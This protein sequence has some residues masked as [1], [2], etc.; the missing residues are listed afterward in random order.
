MTLSRRDLL[1]SAVLS[2]PLLGVP[3]LRQLAFAADGVERGLLVV[4][5]L[6]GGCDGL[7]LI[8]PATDPTFIEARASDLRVQADGPDAGHRLDR[9][10][11]PRI[12]FR[13]HA[14][15]SGLADLYGRDGSPSCMP[16]ASPT[17][18]AATSSP[19]T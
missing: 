13:L 7:N 6:R 17:S 1:K 11:D 2:M 12:D 18:N 14:S 4:V 16:P 9:G 15:A 8:S 3:G 5:H 10:P 19:S